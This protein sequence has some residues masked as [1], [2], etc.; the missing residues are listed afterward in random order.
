MRTIWDCCNLSNKRS[1]VDTLGR[2][3]RR[4]GPGGLA[5]PLGRA[6]AT[7]AAVTALALPV[8]VDSPSVTVRP[9]LG[10]PGPDDRTGGPRGSFGARPPAGGGQAVHYHYHYHNAITINQQPGE[11]PEA[12]AERVIR[13]IERKSESSRRAAAHDLG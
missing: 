10:E 12:L 1:I 7:A 2:G 11:D 4:A 8:I 9:G 3:V 13:A 5:R 6:L